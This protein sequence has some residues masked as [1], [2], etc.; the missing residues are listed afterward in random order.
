M[1]GEKSSE[2]SDPLQGDFLQDLDLSTIAD[3]RARECIARLLNL[4]ETLVAEAQQLRA[5]NQRLRDEVSRLKG[6]QGKP[7]ILPNRAAKT[8][9]SSEQERREPKPWHKG[10][11]KEQVRIDR[12]EKLEV[13]PQT[14]PADA[15]FKGYESVV[16]QDLR[17]TS[18]NVEFLKAKYY[19]RQERQT[20]LAPVPAGWEGGFGPGIKALAITFAYGCNLAQP[21]LAEWFGNM[22]VRIS[23]GEISNLLVSKQES[24]HA[25]KADVYDAGLRSSPWQHL[26]ATST[27]V[28]GKN[29]YC[30]VV[31]NPLYTAYITTPQQDRLTVLSVLRNLREPVYR[32]NDEAL[33][34]LR[35]CGLSAAAI[36]RV[37]RIRWDVDLSE[38]EWQR[39]VEQ[40][41]GPLK[42]RHR[43]YIQEAA[44]V[45]AYHA[46]VGYPVV[47]LLVV[48]DAR[49]FKLLTE[50]LGLC[51]VHEGRHFKKLE[52]CFAQ[53]RQ[54]V[55]DFLKRFWDYYRELLAYRQRPSPQEAE[56]LS[57]A[58]D[59]LFS[60]VTG[61]TALDERIAQTQA[62]KTHL[63]MVLTHP[64]IPLHNNPAELGA[65]TRVRK[66]DVSF[67]PRSA[68]G[69][70]CWDTFQTLYG[71]AKKLGVNFFEYICER[72]RGGAAK[73]PELIASKA[74]EVPL[75]ASW[76]APS[77]PP[78]Y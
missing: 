24:F 65:R 43:R 31:C 4:V 13:D 27:R 46:A 32:I 59:Q 73:L 12:R 57:G 39:Q 33:N 64:E 30:H 69:A 38:E 47:Q 26:D 72:V 50:E 36:E 44:A 68:E 10:S 7:N 11:K 6:Q 51:W 42:E 23:A 53:H 3:E 78:D 20:Y 71:T 9:T 48:D 74:Q 25:E 76:G 58:F 29:Q 54:M 34:F 5:E 14:L 66:R 28:D 77:N 70:Q 17:I 40:H 41:V 45:A 22:G 21:K 37:S 55:E 61:Y 49:Q 67:G 19:S 16:A 1:R 75:G 18:D 56:R 52:P 35:Q 15:E 60:S 62:K 63:L 8:G 2:G